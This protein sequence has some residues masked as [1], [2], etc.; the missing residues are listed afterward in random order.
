MNAGLRDLATRASAA[1]SRGAVLVRIARPA[2]IG[3]RHYPAGAVLEVPVGEF[4]RL[5]AEAGAVPAGP[6]VTPPGGRVGPQA[7][8]PGEVVR[9]ADHRRRIDAMAPPKRP[10]PRRG[11]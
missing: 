8:A 10:W 3:G 9:L 11:C 2:S 4:A 6:L 1:E 7:R 5:V